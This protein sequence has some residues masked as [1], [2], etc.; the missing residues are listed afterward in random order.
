MEIE[1][2]RCFLLCSQNKSFSK[3]AE[4][5]HMTQPAISKQIKKLEA[6]LEVELV[7]RSPQGI[8]LTEAGIYFQ[9]RIIPFVK[10]WDGIRQEMKEM[11]ESVHITLGILPSLAAFYLPEKLVRSES[12]NV[13][14]KTKV[15]DMSKEIMEDILSGKL[16]AGLVIE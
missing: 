5:L 12:E 9:K 3:V 11:G 7:S 6:E 2:L 10:E 16:D 13:H 14:L 1:W 8:E 4:H 15:Y